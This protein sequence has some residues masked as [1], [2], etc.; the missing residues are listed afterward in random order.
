MKATTIV[1]AWIIA[2]LGVYAQMDPLQGKVYRANLYRT[3]VHD[4]SGLNK[5]GG[6]QWSFVTGGPVRSQP[7]VVGGVLYVGSNDGHIYALDASSG[8]EVWKFDTGGKVAGSAAVVNG[9]VIMAS[10]SG[11]VYALN[12]SDGTE[13]WKYAH[14]RAQIASSAAVMDGIVYI[15]AGR[16]GHEMMVMGGG[17]TVAL[18]MTDGQL[19]WKSNMGPQ[20]IGAPATDGHLLFVNSGGGVNYYAL[21]MQKGKRVWTVKGGHQARQINSAVYA[22]DKVYLPFTMEGKIRCVTPDGKEI[23]NNATNPRN[24]EIHMNAGGMFEYSTYSE[25]AVTDALVLVGCQDGKLYAFDAEQG[26]IRWTF[27]TKG[28]IMTSSPSVAGNLV[29]FGSWDHHLY[30]VDMNGKQAWKVKLGAEINGSP[31]PGNGVV[32]V[33]CDDGK[34][35]AVK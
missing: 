10:E 17:A 23:W 2:C 31:W 18:N 13:L 25:L 35:Y 20:G 32:Y 16:G 12:A 15:G 19:I 4:T 26:D 7:V 8:A 3:G 14:P 11:H 21:D 29:Y 1:L 33:G 9:K 24:K 27:E 34:V 5:A 28:P 6:V 22:N 30:A